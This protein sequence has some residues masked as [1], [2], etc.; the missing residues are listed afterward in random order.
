MAEHAKQNPSGRG[1]GLS[2]CKMI[3]EKMGGAVTVSSEIGKGSIFSIEF[4]TMSK[5]SGSEKIDGPKK[6]ENLLEHPGS[7]LRDKQY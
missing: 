2:I 5:L 7:P 6:D 4:A 1:L 3:V